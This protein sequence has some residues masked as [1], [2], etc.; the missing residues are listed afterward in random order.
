MIKEKSCGAVIYTILNGQRLYLIEQMQ[1]GHISLCKGHV[2]GTESEY[3]TATREI[4]EETGLAVEFMEGFR[5]TIEYSSSTDCMKTVVFFLAYAGS[6]DA[7][8]QEEEVKAIQWLTFKEATAVLTF[9]SDREVLQ[10]AEE[11]LKRE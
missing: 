6:T 9:A 2:E 7:T 5:Q 8:V 3:Q 1:K 11:F 10:K 4:R